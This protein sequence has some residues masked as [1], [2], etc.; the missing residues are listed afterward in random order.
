MK[1]SWIIVCLAIPFLSK[2]QSDTSTLRVHLSG[3]AEVYYGFDFGRPTAANRPGFV[4]SHNRHNEFNVNIAFLKSSVNAARF[5][6]NLALMAGTYANA[7]LAAEPGTLR[8]ILEANAGIKLSKKT[9]LWLDAGIFS[10]HIGFES[11][12]G[13]DCWTLTRSM[14]ADNSPYYES[15]AKLTY[16]SANSHWVF[17]ALAL[18]GWQRIQ[19]PPGNNSLGG[20]WQIQ[21][22]PNKRVLLNSST[23]LGNDKPDEERRMRVFH[24]LYG[25]FQFSDQFGLILGLDTGWEAPEYK[26]K[27]TRFWYSPVAIA[28]YAWNK[29][30]ALALRGE[31]YADKT[32]V[33]IATDTPNGFQTLGLSLNLDVQIHQNALWRIEGKWWNSRDAVFL[34]AQGQPS[35]ANSVLTTALSVGF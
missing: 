26:G 22:K 6:A 13:K 5:R 30:L 7:N 17:S 32:G 3:Y 28:R 21:Y 9:D 27:E 25:I 20:G 14:A 12:I 16:A 35:Y 8:N 23:F 15:G 19:R 29:R 2:A 1:K 10:S 4:Y 33:I 31:Y 24:N 11:A 18:N 34:D